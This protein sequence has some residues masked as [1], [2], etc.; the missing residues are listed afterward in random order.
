MLIRRLVLLYAGLVLYGLSS[1]MMVRAGLGLDPWNVLHQ[2][3]ARHL[4]L[5][6]G[7]VIIGLGALLMLVW[8]PLRQRPGIGTISNVVLIGLAADAALALLPQLHAP[9]PRMGMLITAIILNGVASGMYIGAGLGPG[10]RDGLMTGLAARSGWT[11]RRARTG[12]EISVLALGWLLGGTVGVGTVLYALGI[13]MIIHVTLPV[14]QA[15][16]LDQRIGSPRSPGG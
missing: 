6:F 12:I 1:A 5:S 3:I 9:V 14:F 4:Q 8:I 15:M 7:T 16:V 2:G 10:P 11:I 13:G